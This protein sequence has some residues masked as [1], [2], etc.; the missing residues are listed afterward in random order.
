[1]SKNKQKT[2]SQNL[3]TLLSKAI[4]E[5][6][7][8]YFKKLEP[9]NLKTFTS[10]FDYALQ[11]EKWDIAMLLLQK[12][13]S[14]RKKNS[15][16]LTQSIVKILKKHCPESSTVPQWLMDQGISTEL[17]QTLLPYLL[18]KSDNSSFDAAHLLVN[19]ATNEESHKYLPVLADNLIELNSWKGTVNLGVLLDVW[20][21]C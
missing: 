16:E 15:P 11:Q 14:G 7:I 3:P 4:D 10:F 13:L 5:G 20:V 12:K 6:N 9:Q 8:E 21:F 17:F 1:M 2:P 19:A 18:Y